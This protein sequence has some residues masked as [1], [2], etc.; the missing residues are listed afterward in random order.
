M[1]WQL[2]DG[3]GAPVVR[4]RYWLTFQPGEIR[5]C[6]SCHGIN[7]KDQANHPMPTNS[8]AALRTL[9]QYWKT[10]NGDGTPKIT[11]AI[12]LANGQAQLQMKG[13]PSKVHIIQTTTDLVHWLPIG[14]NLTDSN[15]L[16]QFDDANAGSF[17]ARF[18]RLVIP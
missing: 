3:S 16:F 8:P 13:I 6:T 1:T 18:Y 9:L 14:T 7:T 17:P 12:R 15:V 10:K 4:E 5:L 11:S 2:T